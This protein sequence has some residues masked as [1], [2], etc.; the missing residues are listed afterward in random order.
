VK[1]KKSIAAI[2]HI[3]VINRVEQQLI[4]SNTTT[5]GTINCASRQIK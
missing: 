4:K 1:I 5:S 2:S 3:S